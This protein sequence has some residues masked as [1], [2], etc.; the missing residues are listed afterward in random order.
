MAFGTTASFVTSRYISLQT[1]SL[2]DS[3]VSFSAHESG[4]T[5]HAMRSVQ[6]GSEPVPTERTSLNMDSRFALIDQERGALRLLVTLEKYGQGLV[7]QQLIDELREQGVGRSSLYS[8][9][10]A[11]RELG[12]IVDFKMQRGSNYYTV[13]MLTKEGYQLAC[14]L[15]EIAEILDTHMAHD[16]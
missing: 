11:C 4:V 2:T 15:L 10:D 16:V 8:S 9:L 1:R 14:K 5:R 13:S 7:R 6:A 3:Y 12:L